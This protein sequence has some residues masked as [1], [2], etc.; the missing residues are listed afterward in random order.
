MPWIDTE[1]A[2]V[3]TGNWQD[4]PEA[5]Q[6]LSATE[7]QGLTRE[8]QKIA[9]EEPAFRNLAA[10]T[11]PTIAGVA[12]GGAGPLVAGAVGAGATAL[13]QLLGMEKFSPFNVGLAGALPYGI[14]KGIQ[15][16]QKALRT[17]PEF[18]APS[19]VREAGAEVV[20]QTAG[21]PPKSLTRITTP[22]ASEELFRQ[23]RQVG[24]VPTANLHSIIEDALTA[25]IG[26][27][28]SLGEKVVAPANINKA[29]TRYMT[30]LRNKLV[31]NPQLD[32]ADIL[33][34]TQRLRTEAKAAES[35]ARPDFTRAQTF[36][37]TRGK[38]LDALDNISPAAKAA[39]A[40][41][42]MEE[43]GQ[44]LI[45]VMR[46]ERP[47]VGIRKLFETNALVSNTYS[48]QVKQDIYK[49]V[50]KITGL[51]EGAPQGF[52]L[53]LVEPLGNM[54]NSDAGRAF[55]RFTLTAPGPKTLTR[56][57]VAAQFGRALATE[58][59]EP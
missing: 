4:A 25:E 50:D 30:N 57:N 5:L 16:G 27:I 21:L 44:E 13:N 29:T 39:N 38:L 17:L 52:L 11:I 35:G 18:F 20:A 56:L 48:P 22:A 37:E 28:T 59:A 43:S 49:L 54:L 14:S 31:Q 19:A 41:Y 45:N 55:L 34:E 23:A 33:R 2:S 36:H 42:R 10:A 1:E 6:P 24:Q 12:T 32:Y 9:T 26:G 8:R 47:N 7:Q 15:F 51:S 40:R 53:R 46:S 58:R 3:S